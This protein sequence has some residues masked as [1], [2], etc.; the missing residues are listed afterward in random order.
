LSSFGFLSLGPALGTSRRRDDS[1]HEGA[2]ARGLMAV[3]RILTN[4]DAGE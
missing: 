4:S 1:S 2:C 3:I